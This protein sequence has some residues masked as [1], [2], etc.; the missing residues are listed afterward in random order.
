MLLSALV[1]LCTHYLSANLSYS[2]EHEFSIVV[3]TAGKKTL[4]SIVH[5]P[6]ESIVHFPIE[7]LG[8]ASVQAGMLSDKLEQLRLDF[9]SL[10]I[11]EGGIECGLPR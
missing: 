7:G 9:L 2:V 3:S 1:L 10:T 6:I 4:F 11:N 8:P 5:F